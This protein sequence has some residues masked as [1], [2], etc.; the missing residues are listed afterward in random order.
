MIRLVLAVLL[1]A[2]AAHADNIGIPNSG[3]IGWRESIIVEDMPQRPY[4]YMTIGAHFPALSIGI[5]GYYRLKGSGT[6]TVRLGWDMSAHSYERARINDLIGSDSSTD[7]RP[8]V[9]LVPPKSEKSAFYVEFGF[10]GGGY[11]NSEWRLH[12]EVFFI[13]GQITQAVLM[14]SGQLL[15]ECGVLDCSGD[16]TDFEKYLGRIINLS[17]SA[18]S[19]SNVCG[20]GID[21][22]AHEIA[23]QV[24]TESNLSRFQVAVVQN[25]TSNFLAMLIKVQCDR[26]G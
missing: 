3:A 21:V 18:L 19:R 7:W 17:M 22:T 11:T 4:Q 25:I 6:S 13:P 14:A 10:P 16:E 5:V 15:L 12:Y 26:R 20:V 8:N 24:Q 23:R 2:H 1:F 9:F